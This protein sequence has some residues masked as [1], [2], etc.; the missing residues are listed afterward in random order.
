MN[1][2]GNIR[3]YAVEHGVSEQETTKQGLDEKVKKVVA[4]G[5]EVYTKV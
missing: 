5:A 2:H 4:K 3:K 1:A